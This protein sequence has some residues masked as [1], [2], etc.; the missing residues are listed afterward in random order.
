MNER[1][2][3]I[4]AEINALW[5]AGSFTAAYDKISIGLCPIL[6]DRLRSKRRSHHDAEDIVASAM[7]GFAKK[8]RT[9]SPASIA[10]PC[11]YLQA[12]VTNCLLTHV[13]KAKKLP[14]AQRDE[15]DQRQ[16]TDATATQPTINNRKVFLVQAITDADE[17]AESDAKRLVGAVLKQMRQVYQRILRDL[18][19]HGPHWTLAEAAARVGVK[20]GTYAVQKTRAFTTFK[21]LAAPT[22]TDL[23]IEWRGIDE[24]T[25]PN[26]SD[27]FE[28]N[29]DDEDDDNE[30]EDLDEYDEEE[31]ADEG[32]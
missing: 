12:A 9:D 6:R 11:N 32:E 27:Y 14:L 19:K 24:D 26:L 30:V 21:K 13:K 3:Q 1:R 8:L 20:P 25:A 2:K 23:G 4:E 29:R 16:I 5:A 15:R 7:S 10:K 18:L 17:I 22:A 28:E 31:Q